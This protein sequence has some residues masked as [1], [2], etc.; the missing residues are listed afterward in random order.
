MESFVLAQVEV[1]MEQNQASLCFPGVFNLCEDFIHSVRCKTPLWSTIVPQTGQSI[2]V[3]AC[4]H[5][6]I[7]LLSPVAC[8]LL[9]RLFIIDMY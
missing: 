7:C 1:S 2:Q 4:L 5:Q 3:Q 8:C 6:Y 9:Y